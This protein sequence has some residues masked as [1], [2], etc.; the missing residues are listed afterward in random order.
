MGNSLV[1]ILCIGDSH[2]AGFPL[3]DPYFG[4]DHS[5]SYEYWLEKK[6]QNQFPNHSF[7]LENHGVCGEY[8]IDILYRFKAIPN[9]QKFRFILFWG[10]ANDIGMNKPVKTILKALQ[11]AKDYCEQNKVLY[12]FFT[13]PPMNILGLNKRVIDLN[14][15]MHELFKNKVIDVYSALELQGTLKQEYGIGDGVHLSIDGYHQVAKTIFNNL[16]HL[17]LF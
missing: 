9:I 7:E 11:Q 1:S 2:T 8:S 14:A 17:K 13:I 4:G 10:G 15:R 16:I 5:S 3:Y 12:F 6:L